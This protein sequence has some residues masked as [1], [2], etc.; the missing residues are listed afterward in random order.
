MAAILHEPKSAEDERHSRNTRT[1]RRDRISLLVEVFTLISVSFYGY[2]AIRQW[3][4]MIAVRHQA[5]SAISAA[6]RSAR[7]AEKAN[8][9]AFE[10]DRPWIGPVFA[11]DK[12]TGF[13][14]IPNTS[15]Y[16]YSYI[17]HF[18]NA[19]KRPAIMTQIHTTGGWFKECTMHPLYDIKN[20][21]S[22]AL[23]IPGYEALAA[24]NSVVSSE[25]V[26]SM[27]RKEVLY[28]VYALIEY[29]DVGNPGTTHHT[30]LCIFSEMTDATKYVFAS[31]SNRYESAD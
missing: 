4:E 12:D 15:Q 17:W 13:H 30:Q 1:Q 2:M 16:H 20:P 7:A 14:E 9:A 11:N 5:Q 28:C 24:F 27:K 19:G 18:K 3:R 6:N 21:A 25:N 22:R 23:I 8:A 26:E 10:A 31:R 29:K